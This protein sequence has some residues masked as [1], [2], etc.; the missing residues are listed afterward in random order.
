MRLARSSRR[1][2]QV[3]TATRPGSC[4]RGWF[5]D[6]LITPFSPRLLPTDVPDCVNN[7]RIFEKDA[8]QSIYLEKQRFGWAEWR[9][10]TY[11]NCRGV[12]WLRFHLQANIPGPL[13]LRYL[14][15]DG[16]PT[17]VGEAWPDGLAG[18]SDVDDVGLPHDGPLLFNE[19]VICALVA[20]P[21][22]PRSEWPVFG[23]FFAN[24]PM[25]HVIIGTL[26]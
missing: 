18:L 19:N 13:E 23:A 8:P 5:P 21:D 22:R 15:D 2:K 7:E 9:I 12:Q 10:G 24:V 4:R 20:R 3:L 1:G 14:V 6:P 26:C 17:G 25:P 11:G 16:A